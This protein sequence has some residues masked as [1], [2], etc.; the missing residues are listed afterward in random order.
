MLEF[1]IKY[2]VIQLVVGAVSA[3][4]V[5]II[6]F[7]DAPEEIPQ[8]P[9]V[10]DDDEHEDDVTLIQGKPILMFLIS[11]TIISALAI[12]ATVLSASLKWVYALY[13]GTVSLILIAPQWVFL[14]LTGFDMENNKGY[15][16]VNQRNNKLY[17]AVGLKKKKKMPDGTEVSIGQVGKVRFP[18]AFLSI[19][20]EKKN[21]VSLEKFEIKG[22]TSRITVDS[23]PFDWI[24]TITGEPD[25]NNLATFIRSGSTELTSGLTETSTQFINYVASQIGKAEGPESMEDFDFFVDRL[26]KELGKDR[27]PDDPQTPKGYNGSK[28]KY[29]ME[30]WGVKNLQ[31]NVTKVQMDKEHQDVRKGRKQV[32]DLQAIKGELQKVIVP[33]RNSSEYHSYLLRAHDVL[34]QESRQNQPGGKK[35]GGGQQPQQSAQPTITNAKTIEAMDL[36]IADP[37]IPP[38]ANADAA[39][40]GEFEL[41]HMRRDAIVQ[42]VIMKSRGTL[43]DGAAYQIAQ[44][45]TEQIDKTVS[46]TGGRSR[47]GGTFLGI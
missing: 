30:Y 3:A 20:D 27:H 8:S 46:V 13:I 5:W 26:S 29:I 12:L 38:P 17:S 33:P 35:K 14:A 47:G 40:L 36:L 1:W 2:I 4:L 18:Y 28:L 43:T 41:K 45:I 42:A 9:V 10:T 44:T 23:V 37:M 32:Y 21:I 22:V 11:L 15:L 16:F 7:S 6:F 25:E 24:A 39:V 34:T 19:Q 31:I